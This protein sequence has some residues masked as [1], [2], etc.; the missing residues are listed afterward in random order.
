MVLPLLLTV[1]LSQ[2]MSLPSPLALMLVKQLMFVFPCACVP[3]FSLTIVRML[4]VLCYI[5]M[6]FPPSLP[7]A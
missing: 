5:A 1:I 4:Q 3:P 2:S 6:Y 7:Y